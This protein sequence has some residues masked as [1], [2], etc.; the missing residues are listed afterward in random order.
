MAVTPN[1]LTKKKTTTT[2]EPDAGVTQVKSYQT[3]YNC[4]H[5]DVISCLPWK[6]TL[7]FLAT[8]ERLKNVEHIGEGL[9]LENYESVHHLDFNFLE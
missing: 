8:L 5:N 4:T 7:A 2:R 9:Q 3:E 1:N 6:A